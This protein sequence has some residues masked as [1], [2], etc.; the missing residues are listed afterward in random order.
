ME[1][2]ILEEGV[3]FQICFTILVRKRDISPDVLLHDGTNVCDVD[4]ENDD[5]G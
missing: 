1:R 4:G 2:S 3:K 5:L